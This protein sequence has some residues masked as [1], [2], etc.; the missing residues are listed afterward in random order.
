LHP[1]LRHGMAIVNR[2]T[3]TYVLINL[4][5]APHPRRRCRQGGAADPGLSVGRPTP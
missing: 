1:K 2:N 3:L 4:R 5:A